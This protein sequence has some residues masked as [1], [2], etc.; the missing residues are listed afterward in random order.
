MKKINELV[1]KF[2]AG[3]VQRSLLEE[4]SKALDKSLTDTGRKLV[5]ALQAAD[6]VVVVLNDGKV[7][8]LVYPRLVFSTVT[9]EAVLSDVSSAGPRPIKSAYASSFSGCVALPLVDRLH[10]RDGTGATAS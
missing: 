2:Q 6:P 7:L 10:L 5:Q 8:E 9:F 1:K 3:V 4:P